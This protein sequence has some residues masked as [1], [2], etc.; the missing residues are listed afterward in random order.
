MPTVEAPTTR[1]FESACV[2]DFFDEM[3]TVSSF[4]DSFDSFELSKKLIDYRQDMQ[5]AILEEDA[6]NIMRGIFI[7]LAKFD[8]PKDDSDR[9][10]VTNTHL[11]GYLVALGLLTRLIQRNVLSADWQEFGRIGKKAAKVFVP[12]YWR[13]PLAASLADQLFW[14]DTDEKVGNI[15]E[16]YVDGYSY[17]SHSNPDVACVKLQVLDIVLRKRIDETKYLLSSNRFVDFAE[18]TLTH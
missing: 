11:Q 14:A 18:H 15:L 6:E 1:Q 17:A 5:E 7:C 12:E 4:F 16:E 10:E 9:E 2:I 8:V 3:K 13:M